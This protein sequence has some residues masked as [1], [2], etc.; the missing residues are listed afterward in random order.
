MP[1]WSKSL[2]WDTLSVDGPMARTV[3][4]VALVLSAMAGPDAR[5]PIALNE[6]GSLF[7]RPL[8]RDFKGVRAAWLSDLGGVPFDAQVRAVVDAQRSTLAALGLRIEDSEPDFTDA[9]EIFQTL[10]AWQFALGRGEEVRQYR[11]QVKDTVIWNVEQGLKLSGAQVAQAEAKRTELYQR[12]RTFMETYEFL[13]LP[14]VQVPPFPI[15]Q[16]Y[17][18]EINGLPLPT[19]IDWMKSCYYISITGH[20][21][22]SVPCGFTANGLPVGLQIVGRHQDDWGVLQLAHAFEQTTQF[23]KHRPAV[24]DT[25]M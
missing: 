3:A 7:A 1:I 5:S 21:A 18:T 2:G 24:A 15:S 22:I 12:V 4:D 14:T 17:V 9:D 23:W 11:D 25:T 16:P 10:R 8:D 19:Y 20:P 6:P 13:L